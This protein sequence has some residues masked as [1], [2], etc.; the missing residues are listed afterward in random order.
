MGREARR[1]GKKLR[2]E[3]V[4]SNCAEPS[5][6]DQ[7]WSMLDFLFYFL[8]FLSLRVFF[9]SEH[10]SWA[11]FQEFGTVCALPSWFWRDPTCKHLSAHR[12]HQRDRRAVGPPLASVP[13]IF[14][15]SALRFRNCRTCL[16]PFF[17][18]FPGAGRTVTWAS[19]FRKTISR[20]L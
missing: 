2:C 5:S 17:R 7:D 9:Y 19:P 13:T 11:T 6:V 20:G 16:R 4:R 10:M 18:W 15:A 14:A 1:L 8:T 3:K 12:S